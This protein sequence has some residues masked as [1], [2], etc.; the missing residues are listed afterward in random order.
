MKTALILSSILSLSTGCSYL[1]NGN[2]AEVRLLSSPDGAS[3]QTHS[4]QYLGDTPNT[5]TLTKKTLGT[6]TLSF[7]KDGYQKEYVVVGKQVDVLWAIWDIGTCVIPVMLC[8]P[9]LVDGITGGAMIYNDTA[10]AKMTRYTPPPPIV[11]MVPGQTIIINNVQDN[12][13]K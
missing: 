7:T 12:T 4:G 2:T 9:L 5:T 10:I 1:F 8:I 3:V 11:G 13:Q 6:T